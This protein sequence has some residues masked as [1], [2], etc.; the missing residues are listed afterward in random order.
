M[1]YF[2]LT[3]YLFSFFLGSI[4]FGI[5]VARVFKIQ[6]LRSQ[7]S[8]NIG[9]T[10]VSR[11]GGFWPAGF[12]TFVLD[13]GKGALSVFL[14]SPLAF[15][16]WVK[17]FDIDDT[18][19]DP[20]YAWCSGFFSVLGHCFS[21]WLFMKGGKGVSTALGVFLVLSPVSAGVA[22]L[23]F[24]YV[25]LTQRIVSLASLVSIFLATI[26]FVVLNSPGMAIFP[27][28][29]I[30]FIV[31]LRHEHN[32]HS[33][34]QGVEKKFPILLLILAF[35]SSLEARE[36]FDSTQTR[37]HIV[38]VPQ[39]VVTLVPSLGEL[40]ADLLGENQD[41]IVGV[42]EFTDYPPRLKRISSIGPYSKFNIEKVVTLKPDLVLAT[43]DGNSQEQVLHLR[44]LKI[45][46]VVVDTR[47]LLK[48]EESISLVSE[49]LGQADQGKKILQRFN[50]TISKIKSRAQARKPKRVLMQ[51]S[52]YPIIVAG[53]KTFLNDLIELVG[54]RN[55]YAGS[56]S[57][58]PRPSI[59]DILD[60][61]PDV[62]L[63]FDS[64]GRAWQNFPKLQAVRDQNVKKLDPDVLLRP[65]LRILN[66]LLLL[67]KA[68]Y[69]NS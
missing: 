67:E 39:R 35:S 69:G 62:I 13:A 55:I 6:N 19:V 61:N 57:S 43:M 15:K 68:I 11:V 50:E 64:V 45:P 1:N 65:T 60:K 56:E 51:I 37:I 38:D 53:G 9:A 16:F 31:V 59:E 44:E 3:V 2:H 8:G 18:N 54:S 25:F 30:T 52:G 14:T 10:N 20:Y 36:I 49:A 12:L 7:G 27:V 32:L 21:P 33:L 28:I 63:M 17:F 41:R 4:P 48:I 22:V 58:Y 29:G 34:I 66:G 46:V 42:S 47:S 24:I 26:S 23:A 5:L 40:A